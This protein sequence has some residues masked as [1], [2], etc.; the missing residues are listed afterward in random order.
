M[1]TQKE[2]TVTKWKEEIRQTEENFA[3][4]VK[5][6]GIK[7]AF[8]VYADSDAVLLRNN[9]LYKGEKSIMEYF[10]KQKLSG[11]NVILEWKPNFIDVA[12]S[13]ELAYTYGKYTYSYIDS[14]GQK[15]EDKGIFHTIWKRQTDGKWK[16]VWD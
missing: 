10:E 13:G 16:F 11:T 1:E 4:M 7:E 14:S 8:L 9:K 3:K 15:T 2:D 6:S 12:E 5:I